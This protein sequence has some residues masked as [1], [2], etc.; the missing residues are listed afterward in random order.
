[1]ACMMAIFSQ[2]KIDL[3]GYVPITLQTFMGCLIALIAPCKVAVSACVVYLLMGAIGLP[4]FAGFQ[5]GMGSLLGYSGGYIFSFPIMVY[6]ISKLKTRVP[7]VLA[8][9]I[10]SVICYFIGTLW[11]MFV[12]KMNLS[13]SLMMCVVP[14]IPGDLIKIVLAYCLSK[15][16]KV[17]L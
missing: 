6:V 5:G 3:P 14:F 1:M 4:V 9:I 13:A 2:I 11:F 17:K 15:K 8:C 12:T 7:I 16:I 10:G